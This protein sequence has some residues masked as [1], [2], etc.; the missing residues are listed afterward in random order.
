[1]NMTR[2]LVLGA[3][4]A[5]V[6]ALAPIQSASAAVYANFYRDAN[7][8]G[9][10]FN[11]QIPYDTGYVGSSANDALTS[12]WVPAH[13]LIALYEHT[14]FTGQSEYLSNTTDSGRCMNVPSWF[15]DRTSSVAT[16]FQ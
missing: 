6:V 7:C 1:M 3:L 4:A 9:Y 2:S 11:L 14:N 12:V 16:S 8:S 10:M 5:A 13:T 15:N